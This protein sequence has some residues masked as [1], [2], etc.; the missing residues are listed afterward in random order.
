MRKL[1]LPAVLGLAAAVALAFNAAP[2]SGKT[3]VEGVWKAVAVTITNP[4]STWTTEITTPN[5]TIFTEGHFAALRTGERESLPEEATD[6]QRLA[7]WQPFNANAGT[8]KTSSSEMTTTVIV[9]KSPNATAERRSRTST[10]ER[11][12]DVLWRTFTSPSAEF[13]VKYTKLE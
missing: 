6:A 11:D 5:L 7:A 13:R 12:G 1:M 3:A 9:A 4:D 2:N 10:F 8:Y